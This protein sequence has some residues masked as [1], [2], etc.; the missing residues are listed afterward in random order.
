MDHKELVEEA[1]K[2]ML[3]G[4]VRHRHEI[5]ADLVA[6]RKRIYDMG[7]VVE[8]ARCI[9]HWHDTGADG[10]VVSASHVFALWAAL[11]KLDESPNVQI[12][13]QP[14]SGL[15]RSN[16]GLDTGKDK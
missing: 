16:A 6:A 4:D 1:N 7:K 12:E 13:G 15:S 11:D 3:Y 14:A 5:I 2:A 8:A 10:M 9:R